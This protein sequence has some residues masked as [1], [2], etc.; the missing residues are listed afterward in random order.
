MPFA[1]AFRQLFAGCFVFFGLKLLPSYFQ[2]DILQKAVL[3]VFL[4]LD[5]QRTVAISGRNGS[6]LPY[7]GKRRVE[8]S[9]TAEAK[10]ATV[11]KAKAAILVGAMI[12]Q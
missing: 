10:V 12:A 11:S 7:V 2:A 8:S 9:T 1:N 4:K 6:S 5:V 3:Q